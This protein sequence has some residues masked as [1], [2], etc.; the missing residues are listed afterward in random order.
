MGIA[1][2]NLA[3]IIQ[4]LGTRPGGALPY[5]APIV[6]GGFGGA[7]DPIAPDGTLSPTFTL[8]GGGDTIEG[9]G[10]FTNIFNDP[11]AF[12]TFGGV[13]LEG[14]DAVFNSDIRRMTAYSKYVTDAGYIT[15]SHPDLV[16]TPYEGIG[17]YGGGAFGYGGPDGLT[18]YEKALISSAFENGEPFP[19]QLVIEGSELEAS[20]NHAEYSLP[21]APDGV[22]FNEDGGYTEQI[23]GGTRTVAGGGLQKYGDDPAFPAQDT[24]QV[25]A[26]T[27]EQQGPPEPDPVSPWEGVYYDPGTDS[28]KTIP[29]TAPVADTQPPPTNATPEPAPVVAPIEVPTQTTPQ[30][31]P[32]PEIFPEIPVFELETD[33]GR[34]GVDA[35]YEGGGWEVGVTMPVPGTDEQVRISIP[36][37]WDWRDMKR[38]VEK[39]FGPDAD[40]SGIPDTP[41]EGTPEDPPLDPDAPEE[42]INIPFPDVLGGSTSA[43][44]PV[45]D[46]ID[47]PVDPVDVPPIVDGPVDPVDLPP[48]IEQ[49]PVVDEPPPVT[50]VPVDPIPAPGPGGVVTDPDVVP[51]PTEVPGGGSTGTPG[52]GPEPGTP[53]DPTDIPLPPSGGSIGYDPTQP[54]TLNAIRPADPRL[55][56]LQPTDFMTRILA[57][58]A[59]NR[60]TLG[61]SFLSPIL[62]AEQERRNANALR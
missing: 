16:G 4:V 51:E 11:A 33:D 2:A 6:G 62:A 9:G 60:T 56:N 38:L 1:D 39:I 32:E 48:I 31:E 19:S 8:E 57:L 30:P 5:E 34:F 54:L 50:D 53:P 49:P 41:P 10:G 7:I 47:V 14:I 26:P 40:T 58:Q 35:I 61:A 36:G 21:D 22:T 45:I 43:D 18:D 25:N 37:Q 46:P 17:L 20:G 28:F 15:E 12:P 23:S 24:Q 59:K 52:T 42:P 55:L 44:A 3:Q 13:S 27:I 29:T